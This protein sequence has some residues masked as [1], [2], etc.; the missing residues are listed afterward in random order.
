MMG[1]Q[2]VGTTCII[3]AEEVIANVKKVASLA[4][5]YNAVFS[6]KEK[7]VSV[8]RQ[9][10]EEKIGLSIVC[11]T[12]YEE[13]LDIAKQLGIKTHTVNFSLGVWGNTKLLPEPEILEIT[14]LCGHGIISHHLARHYFDKVAKGYCAK[15][16]AHEI[17]RVCYCAIV[18]LDRIIQILERGLP[19]A[20]KI[21]SKHL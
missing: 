17:A 11:T 14:T 2:R 4:S 20:K 16:A 9:N 7:V 1:G 5:T 21:S 12:V 8:L 6:D 10:I 13:T 3:S 15:K 18:N 19:S